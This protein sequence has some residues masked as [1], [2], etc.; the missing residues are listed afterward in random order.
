MRKAL[1]LCVLAAGAV[2]LQARTLTPGEA[3]AR[4][5]AEGPRAAAAAGNVARA[6][7]VDTAQL[8]GAPVYYVYASNTATLFVSADDV[9]APLL[10]YVP[11][12]DIDMA[13]M[14]PAMKWWL[15][16][17]A[18][19]IS[20][21]RNN[22]DK[23][24]ALSY[25]LEGAPERASLSDVA[26]LVQA[27][28]DQDAPYN[29][30]SPSLNGSKTV[31]GCVATAIAQV[32]HYHKYPAAP[33]GSITYYWTDGRKNLSLDFTTLTF[34]WDNMKNSYTGSY[35][36]AQG[37]AVA[38]LMKAVGY[39]VKMN[40]NVASAGGS[41]AYMDDISPAMQSYFDY[42]AQ[43]YDKSNYSNSRWAEL[44]HTELA[45]GR[46]VV[47]GGS[48]TGGGH[49]FVCDGYQASSGKFHFN[50]GWSG[51]YDGYFALT[52]LDPGGNGIG[53]GTGGGFTSG[54]DAV[55][56]S[57]NGGASSDT[58]AFSV[59][60]PSSIS[61]LV[62][63]DPYT[64][65]ADV[66]S[67]YT[68][69]KSV[70]VTPLLCK[71][72]DSKYKIYGSLDPVTVTVPGASSVTATF[73]GTLDAGI[74][75]GSYY[76]I[77]V[78]D[79]YNMLS[80][81]TEVSVTEGANSGS[82]D[83]T[84]VQC[85]T[86]YVVDAESTVT[87]NLKN[88]FASSKTV[89]LTLYIGTYDSNRFSA[90][91]QI[92]SE[93]NVTIAAKGTASSVFTGTITVAAGTYKL[94]VVSGGYVIYD[95]DITVTTEGE[96]G[97]GGEDPVTSGFSVLSMN[98]EQ[99]IVKGK[100][101]SAD[102][103]FY[104]PSESSVTFTPQLYIGDKTD[105]GYSGYSCGTSASVTIPACSTLSTTV[106]GTVT[107]SSS[108][109]AGFH[110]VLAVATIDGKLTVINRPE[111]YYIGTS[112]NK[113]L[114]LVGIESDRQIVAGSTAVNITATFYN[115]STTAYNDKMEMWIAPESGSCTTYSETTTETVAAGGYLSK[116]F[117]L[118]P[119]QL[120]AGDYLITAIQE[121]TSGGKTNYYVLGD[122]RFPVTV[123]AAATYT[124]SDFKAENAKEVE[125]LNMSFTL[126]VAASAA[127]SAQFVAPVYDSS[128]NCVALLVFEPSFFAA[129]TSNTV[130]NNGK[131]E[132]LRQGETYTA[133]LKQ[134]VSDAYTVALASAEFTM[135]DFSGITEVEAA[136]NVEVAYFTLQG[137]R[138]SDAN[139]APG[140]YIRV[141]GH[142]VTKVRIR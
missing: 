95:E 78:D 76:L 94:A 100:A 43:Y 9:A 102:V 105:T 112:D 141:A 73:S 49:C 51:S 52:S 28:W 132:G 46:P 79:N 70:T 13:A 130:K 45:A 72:E 118:S 26:T 108:L 54:Q 27:R 19:E 8:D 126:N 1:L 86:G 136:D 38:T 82:V 18:R 116:T 66:S 131:A 11:N 109:E 14:P 84:S 110:L 33:K 77:F 140:I 7:L 34:E 121:V 63:G 123:P 32:M 103:T 83:V 142:S 6:R 69:S 47:Y 96:G 93:T 41:G 80:P 71:L 88:T 127:L 67:T 39:G 29:N 97:G 44:V 15:G 107:S 137:V 119:R 104:N 129:G 99:A 25:P 90:Q 81:S 60:A 89:D 35:T 98:I 56:M 3:L 16:E 138:V 68:S 122:H 2:S 4:V 42:S 22:P 106:T 40:Y 87:V 113:D 64:I 111:S 128:D 55:F 17:Y 50:W 91:Q 139:L 117:A 37:N 23:A 5:T 58:G 135:K 133:E 10:G 85:T 65:K 101:I 36:T 120:T 74:A 30:Q 12:P 53:G 124:V 61:S 20:W 31:T 62:A 134:V 92:G 59:S 114:I 115:P 24:A 21:A 125:E 75:A 57:P 48:G